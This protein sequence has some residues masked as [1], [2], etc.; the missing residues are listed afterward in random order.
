MRSVQAELRKAV[1]ELKARMKDKDIPEEHWGH[2]DHCTSSA[3][4]ELHFIYEKP[5]DIKWDT[6]DIDD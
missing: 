5:K 4:H 1:D 2:F 3:G 6:S